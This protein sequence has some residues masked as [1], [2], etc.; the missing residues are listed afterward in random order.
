MALDIKEWQ[1]IGHE[2]PLLVNMQPAGHYL[3]E[4]F[5]RAGGIPAVINE[6]LKADLIRENAVTANGERWPTIVAVAKPPIKTSS[7]LSTSH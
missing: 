6:L 1:T 3:G 7:P 5:Y 4:E 2:V